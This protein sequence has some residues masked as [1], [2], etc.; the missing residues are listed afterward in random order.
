VINAVT[1][2]NNLVKYFFL[3]ISYLRFSP[4][5]RQYSKLLHNFPG[6]KGLQT[7]VFIDELMVVFATFSSTKVNAWES[8]H[9]TCDGAADA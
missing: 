4:R 5:I 6:K 3:L 8:G 9:Q 7:T 2:Q 1:S